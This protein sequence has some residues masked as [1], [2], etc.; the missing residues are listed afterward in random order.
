MTQLGPG[1][2]KLLRIINDHDE[3]EGVE[4]V[5]AP[6][7]RWRLAGSTYVVNTR[8]FRVLAARGLIDVGNGHTDPVRA[9][10]AGRDHLATRGTL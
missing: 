1:A 2:S 9:T 6:Y 3:G 8:T 4:F 10:Q 5:P 7:G